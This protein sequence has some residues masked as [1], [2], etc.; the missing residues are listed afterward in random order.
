[1]EEYKLYLITIAAVA[2]AL[3]T[4]YFTARGAYGADPQQCGTKR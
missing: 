2:I 3:L 1:M 4:V